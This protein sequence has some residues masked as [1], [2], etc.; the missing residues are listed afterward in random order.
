MT[1]SILNRDEVFEVM[2]IISHVSNDIFSDLLAVT[3]VAIDLIAES[4]E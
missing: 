3:L 4:V 2:S 1:P